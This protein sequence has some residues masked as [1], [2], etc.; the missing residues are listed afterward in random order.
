[1]LGRPNCCEPVFMKICAGAWLNASVSID[2]TIAMSSTIFASVR[3]QLGELRPALAVL[4]ELE[5]RPQQRRVRVDERGAIALEQLGRRQLAVALRELRLVVEQ[6]E[7]ARRAGLEQEDDALRL[8]R[9]VRLLR[10]ERV[11]AG[12]AACAVPPPRTLPSSECSATEPR[13]TPH[14]LKNQR[15]DGSAVSRGGA[16][17]GGARGRPSADP[18]L[19]YSFVIVSSRFN[20]TRATTV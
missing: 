1:M 18:R 8:R 9:E 10:G 12:A 16:T 6:L 5:L 13:P 2:L 4:G 11:A 14:S 19:G 7:V 3:Q 20:S 15:R 17:G